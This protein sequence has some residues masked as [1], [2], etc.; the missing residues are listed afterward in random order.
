MLSNCKVLVNKVEY[1][2]LFIIYSSILVDRQRSNLSCIGLD[3]TPTLRAILL[4]SYERLQICFSH[5][6]G[7][8]NLL[9]AF[10]KNFVLQWMKRRNLPH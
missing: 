8:A 5:C 7:I 2:E 6:S 1:V 9:T 10:T 4:R 3:Q